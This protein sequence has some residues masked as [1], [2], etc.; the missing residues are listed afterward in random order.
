MVE[1]KL[2]VASL[3]DLPSLAEINRQA[4][5]PELSAQIAFTRW[6]DVENMRIFFTARVRERLLDTG[7]QVFKAVDVLTGNITGFVCWTL[8]TGEEEKP[9]VGESMGKKPDPTQHAIQ[10]IPDF[11]NMEFVMA[12]G[13]EIEQLMQLMKG[14]KHYCK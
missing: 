11:L 1:I 7:T 14:R 3:D 9:G 8:E 12:S 13:A 5:T 10:Q 4:Y 2:E 6:P